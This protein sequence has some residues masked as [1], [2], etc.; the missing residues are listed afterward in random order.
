MTCMSAYQ[1]VI[2]SSIYDIGYIENALIWD[3]ATPGT[4]LKLFGL[5]RIAALATRKW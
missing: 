1:G 4:Y 3:W 2:F 5:I